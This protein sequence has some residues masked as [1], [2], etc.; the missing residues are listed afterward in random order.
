MSTCDP[1]LPTTGRPG[2]DDRRAEDLPGRGKRAIHLA[3]RKVDPGPAGG[4]C[5]DASI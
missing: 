2:E 1:R 4:G 5:N 3:D